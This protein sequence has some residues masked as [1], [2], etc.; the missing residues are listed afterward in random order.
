[1][2]SQTSIKVSLDNVFVNRYLVFYKDAKQQIVI[3]ISLVES[4][5]QCNI[6]SYCF[7]LITEFNDVSDE[8]IKN[9]SDG[10]LKHELL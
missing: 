1:M 9:F 10:N 7:C 6:E 4:E 8:K 3:T 5:E 2:M